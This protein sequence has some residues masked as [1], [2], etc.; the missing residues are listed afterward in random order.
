MEVGYT[1]AKLMPEKW[2]FQQFVIFSLSTFA[3]LLG[4]FLTFQFFY[5]TKSLRCWAIRLNETINSPYGNIYTLS[6]QGCL[7]SGRKI[8]KLPFLQVNRFRSREAFSIAFE[9]SSELSPTKLSLSLMNSH[10]KVTFW[11]S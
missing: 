8:I 6:Q 11:C 2:D 10:S 1:S 9:R 3:C 7:L 4:F 5:R